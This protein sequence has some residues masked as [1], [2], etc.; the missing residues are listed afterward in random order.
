MSVQLQVSFYAPSVTTITLQ[1]RALDAYYEWLEDPSD[2][3]EN[4]LSEM[5]YDQC[6]SYIAMWSELN[7][8]EVVE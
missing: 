2:E 4:Y 8:W 1:G 6:E 3:N 7:E 5:I